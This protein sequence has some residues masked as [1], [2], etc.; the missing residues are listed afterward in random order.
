MSFHALWLSEKTAAE[1]SDFK[2]FP[3]SAEWNG[4]CRRA[5][6]LTRGKNNKTASP[7]VMSPCYVLFVKTGPCTVQYLQMGSDSIVKH[8][9]DSTV[10]GCISNDNKA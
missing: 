8:T 2:Y 7:K 4:Q 5:R 6:P 10:P 9:D 3:L 1:L